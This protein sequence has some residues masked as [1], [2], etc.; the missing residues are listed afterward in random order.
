L[1]VNADFEQNWEVSAEYK[2]NTGISWFEFEI[3]FFV[4]ASFEFYFMF[5]NYIG[6]NTSIERN[7]GEK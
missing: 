7:D 2:K 6:K 5:F 3:G 4:V 1:A